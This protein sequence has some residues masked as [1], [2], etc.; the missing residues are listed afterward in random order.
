[1]TKKL[2]IVC[3]MTIFLAVAFISHA[4]SIETAEVTPP[5]KPQ[6]SEEPKTTQGTLRAINEDG[7]VILEFP[8]KHTSVYA[9]ISGFLAQVEVK[10]HFHN[11]R[12]R[13]A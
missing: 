4:W 10:Q 3:V 8:L 2:R 9:Q 7:E 5:D 1:M 6:I 12:S 11:P 13:P